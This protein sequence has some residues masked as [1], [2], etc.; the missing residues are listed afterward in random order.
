MSGWDQQGDI[1]DLNEQI[2]DALSEQDAERR[3]RLDDELDQEDD[4]G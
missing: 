3:V 1:D 2:A 4:D